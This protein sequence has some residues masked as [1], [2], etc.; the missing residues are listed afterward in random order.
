MRGGDEHGERRHR[1]WG[2]PQRVATKA[3]GGIWRILFV[4]CCRRLCK[5]QCLVAPRPKP[6]FAWYIVC[7]AGFAVGLVTHFLPKWGHLVWMAEPIFDEEPTPDDVLTIGRWRWPVLFPLGA[8]VH[9]HIATRI[10]VVPIPAG[11]QELPVMRSGTAYPGRRTNWMAMR[12][13]ESGDVTLGETRD[14]SLP[15]FQIVNDTALKEMLVSGWK[16]EDDW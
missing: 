4:A 9:R 5:G 2:Q 10:G 1:K 3:A 6:G 12:L 13:T 11:L 15:V 16:P 7:D 8:A 14:K